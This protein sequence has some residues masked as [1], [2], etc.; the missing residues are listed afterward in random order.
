MTRPTRILLVSPTLPWPLHRN[1]GA[2][3]TELLRRALRHWGEVDTV[4]DVGPRSFLGAEPPTPERLAAERVTLRQAPNLRPD[5]S[6][7]MRPAVPGFLR[8]IPDLL[9]R[10]RRRYTADPDAAAWLTGLVREGGYA[11]IVARY[12]SGPIQVGVLEAARA[13][14][15]PAV[16]DFDDIDWLALRNRMAREPWIGLR[17]A[18]GARLVL[19]QTV[20]LGMAALPG[21]EH[22]WVASEEDLAELP[23]GAPASVLPN[24]PFDAD[25]DRPIEPCPPEA[26]GRPPEVLFVG[27]L[28]HPPNGTGL[29][30]FLARVWPAVRSAEP[31][32][33]LRIVGRGLTPELSARWSRTRGVDVV[34]YVDDLRDAYARSAVTVAPVYWGA[35]TKIKVVESA[36]YGRPCVT[37]SHAARG[38]AALTGG[39]PE[40]PSVVPTVGDAEFA[41]ACVAL[42]RDP[43]RRAAMGRAGATTVARDFSFARL[44]SAVDGPLARL[45]PDGPIHDLGD[46]SADGPADGLRHATPHGDRGER[47]GGRRFN[48]SPG[49]VFPPDPSGNGRSADARPDA[50]PT[51]VPA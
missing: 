1:G 18:I 15:V 19:R 8:G 28:R 21:F 50:R 45:L 24:I 20:K 23:A 25:P 14:G 27:D 5:P 33:A 36:A 38:F 17:G 41:A 3:R 37:T 6:W 47:A 48:G 10:H 32:A 26:E 35:G 7:P 39:S 40:G 30:H 9:W 43:A 31:T 49:A 12:L 4:A 11:L 29:E 46:D 51:A 44:R 2:Q 22:V 13:C 16:L 34:G 42:L